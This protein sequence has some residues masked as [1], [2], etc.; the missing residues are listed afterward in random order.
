MKIKI[1][2]GLLIAFSTTSWAQT[3]LWK[4]TITSSIPEALPAYIRPISNDTNY[5][6]ILI[7]WESEGAAQ[8]SDQVIWFGPKG[9][10]LYSEYLNSQDCNY[11]AYGI[12]ASRLVLTRDDYLANVTSYIIYTRKGTQTTKLIIPA[13][14]LLDSDC[15]TNDRSG[16]YT[17]VKSSG[18]TWLITRYVY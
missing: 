11:A 15:S 4:Q 7:S 1:F 3:I 10:I 8:Y 17:I 12:S 18:N 9:S 5:S 6:A 2:L 14:A 13:G 16:F